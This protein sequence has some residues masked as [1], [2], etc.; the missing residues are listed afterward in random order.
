MYK[1]YDTCLM[2]YY[3]MQNSG[4]DALM[5]A[6]LWGAT[7][8]QACQRVQICAYNGKTF[9]APEQVSAVS[10]PALRGVPR[11]RHYAAAAA[12]QRLIIGGGSVLHSAKD[13][14]MKRHMLALAG[15]ENSM[16]IGVGLGPF[17]NLAAEREC[18][19][20]LNECGFIGVRDQL[21]REIAA[22]IA[23]Q[24]NVQLTFDLAPSLL[25]N[26]SYRF[27]AL[28]RRGIAFNF[29]RPTDM[30]ADVEQRKVQSLVRRA[31]ELIYR[32]WRTTGEAIT[33]IDL[34]GHPVF[35]DQQIHR[36]IMAM[37]PQSIP[38]QHIPY[39]RN[40]IRVLQRLFRFKAMLGMRLH[41]A[42]LSYMA[43]TP[44]MFLQY[45]SK[46][47]QWSRQVGLSPRYQLHADSFEPLDM[48]SALCDGLSY[49]FIPNSLPLQDAVQLSLTNWSNQ[50]ADACNFCGHPALQQA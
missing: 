29:C 3:G 16:A 49:G 6:G 21:S 2:G 50:D 8:Q 46:C 15:R 36:D 32:V 12:S 39:D 14:A 23:P 45:H 34:N 9:T 33:L 5:Y 31:G 18:K 11:F 19:K 37:L 17:A 24:A 38:V 26:Q 48:T 42:I 25:C 35:G 4:D 7:Q 44:V 1:F 40:P 30:K 28:E 20:F 41:A 10:A 13:I 27:Q 43:E 47:E 22:D